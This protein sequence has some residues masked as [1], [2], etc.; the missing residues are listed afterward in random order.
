MANRPYATENQ[1]KPSQ[2]SFMMSSI[3]IISFHD[4]RIKG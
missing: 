2:N 4:I 1:N 3:N